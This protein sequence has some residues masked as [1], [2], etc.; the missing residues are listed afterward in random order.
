MKQLVPIFLVGCF[1][2]QPT[3]GQACV[4]WCRR[5]GSGIAGSGERLAVD[6]ASTGD[7]PIPID[8]NYMFVTSDM[9]PAGAIGGTDGGDAWCNQLA[10][11]SHLPGHY[12]A[13]LGS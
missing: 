12:I 2:P 6:A 3:P 1:S 5:R 7:G 8:G 9:K 11:E 4:S 13:W 10:T